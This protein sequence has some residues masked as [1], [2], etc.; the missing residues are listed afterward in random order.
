L[1]GNEADRK[2]GSQKETGRV[3]GDSPPYILP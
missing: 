3:H 2:G 1:R